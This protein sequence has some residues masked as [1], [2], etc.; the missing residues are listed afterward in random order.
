MRG[1]I[2]AGVAA[3]A[4]LLVLGGCGGDEEPD[5]AASEAAASEAPASETAAVAPPPVEGSEEGAGGALRF[6]V[7]DLA[8]PQGGLEVGPGLEVTV[9]SADTA[10]HTVTADDGSFDAALPA[11]ETV[12]FTA[13]A[14]PADHPFHC[15]IHPS[16]RGV[17]TVG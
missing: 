17:L 5:P 3:T 4:A 12:T 13:P 8:F 14:E 1:R 10:A 16:M 11:G 6:Q 7:A 9:T 15:E 2:A